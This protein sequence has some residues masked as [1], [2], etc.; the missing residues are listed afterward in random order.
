M[1]IPR[2]PGSKTKFDENGTRCKETTRRSV[3]LSFRSPKRPATP[4]SILFGDQGSRFVLF[5]L[6]ILQ[7]IRFGRRYLV[8]FVCY[9]L[10]LQLFEVGCN[11]RLAKG[12]S[13]TTEERE[14]QRP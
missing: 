5:L 12:M 9:N 4:S 10:E 13:P 7:Q 6:Q 14:Q 11:H 8:L 1:A 2:F 3:G